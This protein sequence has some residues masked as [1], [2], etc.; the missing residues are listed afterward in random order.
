[1]ATIGELAMI[2]LTPHAITIVTSNNT[3]IIEPSGNLAR[4]TS[5]SVE[6]GE[7]NG[8]PVVRTVYGAVEGMPNPPA[9]CLVS[10]M[11]LAQLGEEWRGIAFAPA[12]GPSDGAIRS[13]GVNPGPNGEVIPKGQIHAVT[14]L[15]TV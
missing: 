7:H 8:I 13:D 6:S 11:V 9:P 10:G 12:T 14:K 2:N 3:T 15:V 4:V 1:M 5:Q